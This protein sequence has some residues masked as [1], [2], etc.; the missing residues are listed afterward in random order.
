MA[1]LYL[2][3]AELILLLLYFLTNR[4]GSATLVKHSHHCGEEALYQ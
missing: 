1:K 4:L 3:S 2:I